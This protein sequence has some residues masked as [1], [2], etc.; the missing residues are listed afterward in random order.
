MNGQATAVD[1]RSQSPQRDHRG[2][3]L[4]RRNRDFGAED[5]RAGR[6]YC[7][8][9]WNAVE[10]FWH[11]TGVLKH[12]FCDTSLFEVHAW[13]KRFGFVNTLVR[14]FRQVPAFSLY[15]G[16]RSASEER[17]RGCDRLFR[18]SKYSSEHVDANSEYRLPHS[19]GRTQVHVRPL[20]RSSR[21]NATQVGER[22][23]VY[24]MCLFMGGSA[25]A[26]ASSHR[27][28]KCALSVV[29]LYLLAFSFRY[30]EA[31]I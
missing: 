3:G 26:V 20:G 5:G 31:V 24:Y 15:A 9:S 22:C 23:C 14:C 29:R 19:I 27:A 18:P 30:G 12:C 2:D 25:G 21:I 7:R 1:I 17:V 4:K 13:R 28:R 16:F 8:S 11:A 6:L 10:E